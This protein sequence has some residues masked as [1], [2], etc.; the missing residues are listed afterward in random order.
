M[1][2]TLNAKLAYLLFYVLRVFNLL[3]KSSWS[4]LHV[5][6]MSQHYGPK[7]PNGAVFKLCRVIFLISH[8]IMSTGLYFLV[9]SGSRPQFHVIYFVLEFTKHS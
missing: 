8:Q 9:V 7:T 5:T 2:L 3:T 6:V 4:Y 1:T